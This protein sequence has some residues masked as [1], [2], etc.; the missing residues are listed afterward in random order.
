MRSASVPGSLECAGS[1]SQRHSCRAK[2][3]TATRYAPSRSAR[4][5]RTL[6]K[7]RHTAVTTSTTEI[8]ADTIAATLAA[9][10][11]GACH[12]VHGPVTTNDT[13]RPFSDAA[14]TRSDSPG[15]SCEAPRQE[16]TESANDGGVCPDGSIE[17]PRMSRPAARKN[18][19]QSG[20]ATASLAAFRA[21][22][23]CANRS[24]LASAS[25]ST[26]ASPGCEAGGSV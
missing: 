25:S 8:A 24:S 7:A 6:V 4:D 10:D 16:T 3:T 2:A 21:A 20:G 12:S 9:F 13:G 22:G 19:V 23:V 14:S 17:K 1:N 26:K 11:E 18:A 15:R 5:V